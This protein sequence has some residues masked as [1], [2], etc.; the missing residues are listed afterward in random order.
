[1]GGGSSTYADLPKNE[2]LN[3]LVS[4]VILNKFDNTNA[5]FLQEVLTPSDPFWNSLLSYNIKPPASKYVFMKYLVR[6]IPYIHRVDWREFDHFTEELQK[7]FLLSNLK[8][9]NFVSLL[10]V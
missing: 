3:R 7:R 4:K 8:T 6:I 1:M 2:H 10:K 5:L 9:G